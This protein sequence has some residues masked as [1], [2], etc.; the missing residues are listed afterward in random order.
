MGV[1]SRASKSEKHTTSSAQAARRALSTAPR[2][3]TQTKKFD[4]ADPAPADRDNQDR[5]FA[6]FVEGGKYAHIAKKRLEALASM[7]RT[8]KELGLRFNDPKVLKKLFEETEDDV[9]DISSSTAT[10]WMA[11]S[12]DGGAGVVPLY[13]KR[14]RHPLANSEADAILQKLVDRKYLVPNFVSTKNLHELLIAELL[15]KK[16]PP[17]GYSLS[18]VCRKLNEIPKSEV[19]LKRFG[20]GS[21][22]NEPFKNGRYYPNQKFLQRVE[23][24]TKNFASP[25]TPRCVVWSIDLCTRYIP[26]YHVIDHAPNSEAGLMALRLLLLQTLSPGGVTGGAGPLLIVADRGPEFKKGF[27]PA[28]QALNIKWHIAD[29]AQ[30]KPYIESGNGTLRV[31]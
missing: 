2:A 3:T 14:G 17:I 10:K 28:L 21:K 13:F 1:S 16:I 12:K 27:I 23:M 18:S 26:A 19:R 29:E 15:E 4:E 20:K 6:L 30:H 22:Q 25:E 8:G 9:Y 7:E 5:A 11:R 24:D 31:G